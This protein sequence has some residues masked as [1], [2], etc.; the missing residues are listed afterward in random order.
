M[1]S[2][3]H[4]RRG[5]TLIE[6]LVVIAI[7]GLLGSVAVVK[8]MSYLEDAAVKT[9]G[10]KLRELKKVLEVYYSQNMKYPEEL[11]LLVEPEDETKE[12]VLNKSGLYDAWK[13]EI[14]YAVTE[15]DEHPFELYSFGPDRQ[16][17]TDDDINIW[18]LEEV[19]PAEE[20]ER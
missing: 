15:N 2:R 19:D 13:Q 18:E 12:G 10:E 3:R 16:D 17:G 9:T 7:L 8:Y 20:E 4:G 11:N 14:Q 5:F 1:K 6:I